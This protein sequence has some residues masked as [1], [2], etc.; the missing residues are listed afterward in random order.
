ME[1]S[2][3][4]ILRGLIQKVTDS[5][6]HLRELTLDESREL[7]RLLREKLSEEEFGGPVFG[8]E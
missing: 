8:E 4:A 3:L 5:G 7:Q 1:I 2:K 6:G